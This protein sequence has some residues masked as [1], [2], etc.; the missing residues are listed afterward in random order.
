MVY[1]SYQKSHDVPENK[2]LILELKWIKFG[3]YGSLS[4][5]IYPV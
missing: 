2:Y 1:G 5:V 4:A 3:I